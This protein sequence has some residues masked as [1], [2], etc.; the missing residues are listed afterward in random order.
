M[1]PE[2]TP[3][4]EEGAALNAFGS[5]VLC[6]LTFQIEGQDFFFFSMS[7]IVNRKNF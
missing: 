4:F 7:H 5:F 1:K 3:A 6:Y 2:D